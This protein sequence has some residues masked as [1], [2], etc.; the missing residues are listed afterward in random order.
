MI[1]WESENKNISKKEGREERNAGNTVFYAGTIQRSWITYVSAKVFIFSS[2]FLFSFFTWRLI[3]EKRWLWQ[4]S[5]SCWL[6]TIEH[7]MPS[8]HISLAVPDD[9]SENARRP[10]IFQATEKVLSHARYDRLNLK[11]HTFLRISFFRRLVLQFTFEHTIESFHICLFCPFYQWLSL[12][13][14]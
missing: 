10:I 5:V 9:L 4:Q 2:S 14:K 7:A 11:T 3:K 8:L 13:T 6:K 12:S 1:H